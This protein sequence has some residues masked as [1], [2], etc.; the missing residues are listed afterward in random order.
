MEL[1]KS[2]IFSISD[3][4]QAITLIAKRQGVVARDLS[5]EE[6]NQ[7]VKNGSITLEMEFG[8][9]I[10]NISNESKILPAQFI[11]D[12]SGRVQGLSVFTRNVEEDVIYKHLMKVLETTNDKQL[13][14]DYYKAKTSK[15]PELGPKEIYGKDWRVKWGYVSTIYVTVGQT[16]LHLLQTELREVSGSMKGMLAFTKDSLITNPAHLGFSTR[17][18]YPFKWMKNT[19]REDRAFIL[20][21]H[22]NKH[23][24]PE[25]YKWK[26][27]GKKSVKEVEDFILLYN[28]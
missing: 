8:E 26:N 6:I 15:V 5:L 24:L 22:I 10:T 9:E 23:K 25:M 20:G 18:T 27:F 19:S 3:I 11:A 14:I 12:I 7:I 4:Q 21:E 1:K 13:L 28:L 2:V 16:L 17:T